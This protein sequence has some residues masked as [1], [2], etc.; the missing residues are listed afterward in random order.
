[1]VWYQ[2]VNRK[3]EH[4]AITEVKPSPQGWQTHIETGSIFFAMGHDGILRRNNDGSFEWVSVGIYRLET[5]SSVALLAIPLRLMWFLVVLVPLVVATYLL[6]VNRMRLRLTMVFLSLAWALCG[7]AIYVYH[8]IYIDEPLGNFNSQFYGVIALIM[9][10]M[11][12][13][14]V[15]S[16][17]QEKW[18]STR[19]LFPLAALVVISS[20]AFLL[21]Y[22]LCGH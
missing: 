5:P 8:P 17:L 9:A 3:Y 18:V 21:P 15:I 2:S 14:S 7:L 6:I 19:V 13:L 11:C 1:M 10:V 20:V 4:D 16:E 22:A 12:F